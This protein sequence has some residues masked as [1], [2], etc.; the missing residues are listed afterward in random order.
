MHLLNTHYI[1]TDVLTPHKTRIIDD[2]GW[3]IAVSGQDLSG[4][5]KCLQDFG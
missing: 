2:W 1:S 3:L 5:Q 4:L